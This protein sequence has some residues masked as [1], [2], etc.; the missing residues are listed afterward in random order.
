MSISFLFAGTRFFACQNP[1]KQ[2]G[3]RHGL[4]RSFL[5]RFIQVHISLLNEKDLY[6]ILKSQFP[7]IP[8]N[9]LTNMIEF[10]TQITKGIENNDFGTRGAP[11]EYNLRD[12]SRWCEASVYHYKINIAENKLYSPESLVNLIYCDRMRTPD[13]RKKV[14]EIFEAV[15]QTEVR[16][17]S[18]VFY[19]NKHHVYVG[20]VSMDRN[21]SACNVHVLEQDSSCLVLRKQLP[22]LRSLMYCVNLN[23]LSILVSSIGDACI[24]KYVGE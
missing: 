24:L 3:S 5:N 11:W 17:D 14:R 23:W 13:D 8:E 10:N 4:P 21:H 6:L 7:Q 1:L 12:I 20:D 15:F 22:V 9:I 19:V 2:G 16:G 18:A